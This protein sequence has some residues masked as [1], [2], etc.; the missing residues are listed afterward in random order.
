MIDLSRWD[1]RWRKRRIVWRRRDGQ[2]VRGI[3][4]GC[5]HDR[6]LAIIAVP[7]GDRR[8]PSE[9]VQAAPEEVEFEA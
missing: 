6:D 8:Q 4:L 3:L 7:A 5:T 9:I 2:E 1:E